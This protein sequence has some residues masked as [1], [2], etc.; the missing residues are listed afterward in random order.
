VI[1][2]SAQ[3]QQGT[4]SHVVVISYLLLVL[5]RRVSLYHRYNLFQASV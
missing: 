5:I 1:R 3:L 2:T 4:F